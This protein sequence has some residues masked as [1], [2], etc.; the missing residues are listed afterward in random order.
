MMVIQTSSLSPLSNKARRMKC[1]VKVKRDV[2]DALKDVC[3]QAEFMKILE[4]VM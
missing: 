1:K 4:P 3:T 2:A